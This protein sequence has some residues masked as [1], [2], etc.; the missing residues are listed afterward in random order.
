MGVRTWLEP[1]DPLRENPPHRVSSGLGPRA[2]LLQPLPRCCTP[3]STLLSSAVSVSECPSS[4]P[5]RPALPHLG[6]SPAPG[7][8]RRGSQPPTP[9]PRHPACLQQQQARPGRHQGTGGAVGEG[10]L[11]G[12]PAETVPRCPSAG[13]RGS[14]RGWESGGSASAWCAPLLLRATASQPLRGSRMWC[15]ACRVQLWLQEGSR[16]RGGGAGG[17]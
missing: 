13:H 17:E 9:P 5:P 2:L 10:G 8:G 7:A 14:V 3:M 15:Q 1:R 11:V 4:R 16:G 6:L 12:L